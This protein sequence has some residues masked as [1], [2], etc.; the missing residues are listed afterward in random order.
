MKHATQIEPTADRGK[1]EHTKGLWEYENGSIIATDTGN[2]IAIL[3]SYAPD[4]EDAVPQAQI[5]ADGRL[6]AAAPVLLTACVEFVRKV[7]CGEAKSTRSYQ[8]MKAA[9]SKAIQA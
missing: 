5:D 1:V 8:Q 4:D 6:L 7:E 3:N 9:I 2:C